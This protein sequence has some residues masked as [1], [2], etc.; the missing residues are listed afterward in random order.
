MC[1]GAIWK[2]FKVPRSSMIILTFVNSVLPTE[3]ILE[4]EI[5]RIRPYIPR[6]LQCFN[7]YGFGHTSRVCTRDKICLVCSQPEHG[8]C[9]RAKVCANCKEDHHARDKGCKIFKKEQEALMKSNIE[10][11]SVGQ[12]KKLLGKSKYSEVV[13]K[14]NAV[15][16]KTSHTEAH[17]TSSDIGSGAFAGG[18]PR[19][20]LG[21]A[22]RSSLGGA[23]RASSSVSS[24]ASLGGVPRTSSS[25]DI[26]GGTNPRDSRAPGVPSVGPRVS[27]SDLEIR[28]ESGIRSGSPA[29]LDG[30]S[31]PDSLFGI[32]S[33]PD[34]VSNTQKIVVHR[35]DDDR[36]MESLT[37]RQKRARTPSPN[38]PSR[39]SNHGKDKKDSKS[40]Q[41]PVPKKSSSGSNNRPRNK[42]KDSSNNRISLSRSSIP[43]PVA[44]NKKE[45]KS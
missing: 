27:P 13:K 11:I 12:A 18:A 38:S 23:P 35:S 24:R 19:P 8:D 9:S 10:H 30:F 41:G 2:V 4:S 39:S 45:P 5:M 22:R 21:G 16:S 34:P 7:C 44:P 36:E 32:G 25:G 14:P 3:I 31:L 28:T 1:P 40:V 17:Q 15:S 37:I 43:K 6:V 29:D 33:L 42:D 26:S 20:S